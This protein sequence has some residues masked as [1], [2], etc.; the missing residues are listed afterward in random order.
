MKAVTEGRRLSDFSPDELRA[1]SEHLDD[2]VA[3]V[4]TSASW[5]ESKVSEGGTASTRVREQ[6]ALARGLLSG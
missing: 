2:G 5:L 3:E 1:H 4:L 6:L